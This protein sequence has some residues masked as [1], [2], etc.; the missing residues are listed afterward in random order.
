MFS[1]RAPVLPM[2]S[3]M[4]S[5]IGDAF[6]IAVVGYGI[7]ISLGRTFG[8]KFGYKVNSNQVRETHK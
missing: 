6:A 5:M 1:L 8:L 7:A 3:M 2:F 4:G